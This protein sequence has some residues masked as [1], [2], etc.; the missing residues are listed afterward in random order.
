MK[1]ISLNCRV[2][3]R[4]RDKSSSHYWRTRMGLIR[5]FI[6]RENPD[7]LCVQELSFPANL[8]IPQAYRRVGFSI[9]HHIYVRRG[10]VAWPLWFAIHHNGA[11]VDG[12]RIINVHGTWRKCMSKVWGRLRRRIVGKTI[13]IGDFNQTED[14]VLKNLGR[15]IDTGHGVTF[16]NYAQGYEYKPD[17]CVAFGV[18]AKAGVFNDDFKMS[19]HLPLIVTY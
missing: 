10:I 1:I 18:E 12:V 7:V 3:T 11:K 17:H 9:S 15:P 14:A 4:D 13:V 16:H 2:W 5:E 6:E 19:D 8:Y